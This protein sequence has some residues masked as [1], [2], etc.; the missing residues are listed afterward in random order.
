MLAYKQGLEALHDRG[1]RR[2]RRLRHRRLGQPRDR[3]RQRA[4]DVQ[5]QQGPRRPG[6]H[7][8]DR[9][10]RR[11]ARHGRRHHQLLQRPQGRRR[12]RRHRPAIAEALIA[13][14]V[15]LLVAIPA[16][17][18]F[19]YFTARVE[20]M[21]VDM[22]DVSSEFIDFVLR[23]GRVLDMGGWRRQARAASRQKADGARRASAT[24]S[25]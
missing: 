19:N 13:T 9:A 20:A 12:L 3:A 17:M 7:R 2:R 5:P 15:G 14:A 23:E 1:P 10:V 4:R 21:V 18:A 6:H 8:F 25:T 24:K 16:A 22:N 11:S